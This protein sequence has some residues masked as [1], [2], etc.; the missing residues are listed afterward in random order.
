M[1]I[2]SA[3]SIS[4][5]EALASAT[6]VPVR[7][8]APVEHFAGVMDH[9]G[10]HEWGL[11]SIRSGAGRVSRTPELLA[12]SPNDLALFSLQ[13][14]G[15][16]IVEQDG[17]LAHVGP[18]D[19]VLYLTGST[20]RLS[21]P[22][23][24]EMA[25]LQVPLDRLDISPRTR[26]VLTARALRAQND[27]A[28]RTFA[29]VVR[30]LFLA[31]PVIADPHQALRVATEVLGAALSSQRRVSHRS[32]SHAALF[33]AFDRLVHERIDDPSLDVGEL[34][35]AEGVSV[36]TV[37][38]VFAERSESPAAFIRAARI[39]RAQRLLA[40]TQLPLVDIAIR[41][42]S[43]DPS[44]FSR[45]FRHDTGITPSEYRRRHGVLPEAERR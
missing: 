36:R 29:R 20:Y 4:E 27:P 37:H 45:T 9:R 12:A 11:T 26:S 22:Q 28:L 31:R 13:I 44:V 23:P 3:T 17:R 25:I 16:S 41:C 2:Y 24:S 8:E 39:R 10:D 6:F 42:G 21:F 15:N 19:S 43:S 35:I 30:S 1:A 34:A 5:W 14:R 33:A 40:T 18:G 32:R 38:A 7:V